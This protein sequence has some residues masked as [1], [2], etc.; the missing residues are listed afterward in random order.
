MF[1]H[2]LLVFHHGERGLAGQAG[3]LIH[4]SQTKVAMKFEQPTK[5]HLETHYADLKEKKF[6]PGLIQYMTSGPVV[7]M[8]RLVGLLC[9][10]RAVLHRRHCTMPSRPCGCALCALESGACLPPTGSGAREIRC[11]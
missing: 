4:T 2:V 5:E 8:V 11:V 9:A 3:V 7:P 1:A 6:F 10:S